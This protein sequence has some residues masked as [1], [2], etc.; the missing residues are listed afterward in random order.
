[1]TKIC[2]TCKTNKPLSEYGKSARYSA[3][4][5]L[6]RKCKSCIKLAYNQSD[7]DRIKARH[8]NYKIEH[9]ANG[10]CQAHCGSL[11]VKDRS[12]CH[13]CFEKVAWGKIKKR[14]GL[15]KEGWFQ[16]LANQGSVCGLCGEEG[17]LP[18]SDPEH[19]RN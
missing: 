11:S 2:N 6:H 18:M 12:L 8:A 3:E 10:T 13:P 7:K 1:M 5:G 19:K 17:I 4:G 9:A 14:F 15:T 16:L